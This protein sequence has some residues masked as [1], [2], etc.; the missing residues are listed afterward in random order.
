MM[1]VLLKEGFADRAYLARYTDFGPDIEAH[2]A[3]KTPEWA[4]AITG[5]A[6]D[7]IVGLRAA[8]RPAPSA[9]SCGVGFGFT[10]SR[11]GSAGMHAVTCLP[12]ITGAWQHRGGG[13]FFLNL[14]N[15][16]L[17]TTLAHGLDLIDPKTR[18]IDQSRI[19]PMLCGDA[20]RWPAARRSWRC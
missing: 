16:K 4:A 19:G 5:L 18:I 15:W 10:R 3:D 7:E 11:N 13:A 12:A 2:L 17:D 20:T 1:H 8:L 9:A 6:A 14:D